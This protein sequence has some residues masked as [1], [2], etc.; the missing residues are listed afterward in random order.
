MERGGV[1]P[2][3]FLKRG[4]L[5][6]AFERAGLEKLLGQPISVGN[7]HPRE[8]KRKLLDLE[9]HQ[10]SSGFEGRAG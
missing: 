6:P 5:L 9:R 3:L 1:K 8:V 4:D 7:A 2:F 10:R